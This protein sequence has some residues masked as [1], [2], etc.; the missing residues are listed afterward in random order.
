MKNLEKLKKEF[1][2]IPE[3]QIK[4]LIECTTDE[5]VFELG[6]CYWAIQQEFN[7]EYAYQLQALI[8]NNLLQIKNIYA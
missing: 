7:L 4:N 8:E 1:S 3:Y 6:Y 5:L 2:L